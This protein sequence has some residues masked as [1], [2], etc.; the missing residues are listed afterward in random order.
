MLRAIPGPI[1]VLI[2]AMSGGGAQRDAIEL[3]NG[4]SAAG[5]PITVATLDAQGPLRMRLDPSVPLLDLGQGR[6]LR[7]ARALPV[8]MAMMVGLRPQAVMSSEA[9]GNVLL[10]LAALQLGRERPRIILREV[11]APLAARRSDPHLQNRV[12]YW[13][14]PWLYPQAERV[15]S[16]TQGVRRE[17]I[18]DFRVAPTRA[19]NLGTN[20]VLTEA[21][22]AD[23]AQPVEREPNLIVAV[24]RLSPEKGFADL[25]AAFAAVRDDRPARLTILGEG[26][27]RPRLERLVAGLGL[28][29]C[30]ALPGFVAEPTDHVRRAAL[31]VSSSRHEGFGN[32][33]VEALACGTPVV[34]TDAPHGPREILDHGRYGTLVPVGNLSALAHAIHETL[35]RAPDRESLRA[36]AACYTTE[37]TVA[38]MAEVFGE[39]GLVRDPVLEGA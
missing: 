23:L 16:F 9:S 29:D 14:A 2:R 25:I 38:R 34:A 39:L 24:G 11:A 18:A 7:M 21:R 19:I 15:L 5:W 33:I 36:R 35:N 32:A 20:A 4:L 1:I 31:L 26:P 27:E 28:S 37:A 22:L 12:G 30:V 3:A 8:L 10:S 6:R 17:L 13:L